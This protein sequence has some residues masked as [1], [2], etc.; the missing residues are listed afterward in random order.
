MDASEVKQ[1]AKRIENEAVWL[2]E[3]FYISTFNPDS[4]SLLR[5]CIETIEYELKQL[6]RVFE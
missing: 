1:R 5:R 6:K 3:H 4:E 2:G